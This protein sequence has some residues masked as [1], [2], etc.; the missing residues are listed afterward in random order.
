MTLSVSDLQKVIIQSFFND[1]DLPGGIVEFVMN[2]FPSFAWKS[3]VQFTPQSHL[4]NYFSDG[5][6]LLLGTL[7]IVLDFNVAL[8]ELLLL[9]LDKYLD[10]CSYPF[11]QFKFAIKL[12]ITIL[13]GVE[14]NSFGVSRILSLKFA[15]GDV[16]ENEESENEVLIFEM[17]VTYWGIVN[18]IKVFPFQF[19]NDLI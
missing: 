12:P 2:D 8:S 13:K 6:L 16:F 7:L 19:E 11:S 14:G 3:R 18:V 5:L 4:F 1:T 15:I 10:L 9:L 17:K